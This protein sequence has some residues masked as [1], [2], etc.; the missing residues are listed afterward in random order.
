MSIMEVQTLDMAAI[1][2]QAYE[3][4]DLINRSQE[5]A[6]FLYWKQ[7]MEQDPEAQRLIREL[8]KMK[9]LFEETQRFGHYHPNYH[10]A[11]D[12][13][14]AVER[15]LDGIPSVA[16]YKE[17]EDRLDELLYSVSETIAKSVS[18]SIKVPSNKLEPIGHG[19][20]SGGSCSGKCG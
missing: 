15:K 18:E 14:R 12:K 6:D 11:L 16:R 3:V 20:S 8:E 13:V 10:E 19:C 9:E 7:V 1:L 2:M 5:A 4:G 17:A